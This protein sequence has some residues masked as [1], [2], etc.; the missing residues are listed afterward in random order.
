MLTPMD[1]PLGRTVG[2]AL[3]V[4]EAVET[5]QNRGPADLVNLTL[6]LCASVSDR[7]REVFAAHLA[8]GTAWKKFVALVEAQGGNASALEKMEAIHPALVIEPVHA[9][10]PGRVTRMD[11]GEIGRVCVRL[12]AGR[13]LASD[14][15][16]FAVGLSGIRK[17]GDHVKTGE[18][19]LAIHT[20]T[21]AAAEE[22]RLALEMAITVE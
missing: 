7:P 10:R 15:V 1:E 16:D 2:N 21:P 5:L 8:S 22:A 14:T 12:G 17:V 20:H 4:R 9:P 19:L 6:D 3:E 13:R 11:A 18:P